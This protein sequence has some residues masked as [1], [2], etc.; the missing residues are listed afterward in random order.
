MPADNS[1]LILHCE[2]CGTK[3]YLDPYSFFNFSGTTK[4]AG[5]GQIYSISLEQGFVTKGPDKASGEPDRLPGY[6]ENVDFE[7]IVGEGKTAPSPK[8]QAVVLGKPKPLTESIR[9]NPLS[10]RPLTSDELVGSRPR[11]V[12]EG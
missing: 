2:S 4:C 12:I 1:G 5:C 8:A 6:A 9:G 3:N 7:P 10:G 11:F